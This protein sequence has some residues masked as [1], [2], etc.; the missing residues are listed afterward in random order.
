MNYQLISKCLDLAE[1]SVIIT[2]A[3]PTELPG[4]R[5][6]YV[7]K[8]FTT[9]TGYEYKEVIGETPRILQGEKTSRAELDKISLALQEEKYIRVDVI[10]YHKDGQAFWI[11]LSISPIFND[12]GQLEYFISVQKAIDDRKKEERLLINTIKDLEDKI[13]TLN[14]I[15]IATVHDLKEPI[16]TIHSFLQLLERNLKGKLDETA[17]EYFTY[18]K[19]G[20]KR[21]EATI[22]TLHQYSNI[23]H[24][25]GTQDVC[26]SEIISEARQNL[27]KKIEEK[28]A[29]LLINDDAIITGNKSEFIRLFQNLIDNS[30]KHSQTNKPPVIHVE[31]TEKENELQIL[32]KDNGIGIPPDFQGKIFKLFSK[33]NVSTNEESLGAGLAICDKIVSKNNGSINLLESSEQGTTFVIKFPKEVL[34]NKA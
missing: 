3:R 31:V 23:N 16:R 15:S 6:I 30:L 12:Q 28:N 33:F 5:I 26:L 18:I 9:L 34:V 19:S 24:D 1:D 10:N 4:P 27:L 13:D 22:D 32:V 29:T 11:E 7:N 2:E 8:A 20:A 14:Q 17:E 21:L 25:T